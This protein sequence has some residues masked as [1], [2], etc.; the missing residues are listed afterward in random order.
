MDRLLGLPEIASAHGAELD[1]LN[2]YLHWLMLILFV[3]WAALFVFMLFRFRKGRNPQAD[4]LGLKSHASS[5]AEG[6]IAIA[7]A[8]L[9]IA[10]S[11]PLWSARVEAFPSEEEA[12][13]VR[14]V[15]E[16]FAWNVHYPGPD[17]LFG[18]SDPSLVDA[19][20]NPLGLDPDDPA[21]A[22]DIT[23]L[24]QLHLPV[25]RPV[26][27]HLSTKD[28][29]HSFGIPEMRV[30]QD[31]V[32]GIEIP[33]WFTPTVT[34]AEMGERLG[35]DGPHVYEIAC[36]QLCGIGHYRMRGFVTV[37]SQ[38]EFDAWLAEQ[39]PQP[40]DEADSFWN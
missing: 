32:P 29:L 31:A 7:E 33:V 19:Q 8:V 27:V 11:I 1:Q 10:F 38:E 5:Y 17:G 34:S 39:A 35:S 6:A 23:T 15:A 26:I 25:D 4:Y 37:E 14:L 16:Q 40:G 12:L 3:G 24:N 22:D 21:G 13:S 36:A 2:S 9:L 20:L 28:V 30:K 18:R